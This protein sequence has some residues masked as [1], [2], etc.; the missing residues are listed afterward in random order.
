[1]FALADG[2]YNDEERAY[3]EKLA[4]RIRLTPEQLAELTAQAKDGAKFSLSRDPKEARQMIGCLVTTAAADG[5]VTPTERRL[6]MRIARHTNLN[7]S[8]V[9]ELIDKALAAV[10]VDDAEIRRRTDDIYINFHGWSPAT[11]AAKLDEFARYGHQAVQ[12]LL[13]MLESY[14]APNG[15]PNSLDLK[16]L[17]ATKLGDLGDGRSVYYLVQQVT[18]G[19]QDDEITCSALRWAAAEALGRITGHG[20]SADEAGVAAVRNWWTTKTP[21]RAKYDKLVM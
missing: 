5:K 17:I 1:V 6:L 14:R 16:R 10:S 18:I 4:D 7:E 3:I 13:R 19:E 15:E 9:A 11:R 12:P 21:D 20:F 2:D 8:L